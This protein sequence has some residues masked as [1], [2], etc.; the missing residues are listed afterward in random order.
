[1]RFRNNLFY[2]TIYN[3]KFA[4][5]KHKRD[6]HAGCPWALN[7]E[8][9][10]FLT[11]AVTPSVVTGETAL[12][13]KF[14]RIIL[15]VNAPDSP[16]LSREFAFFARLLLQRPS[17]FESGCLLILLFHHFNH[18]RTSTFLVLAKASWE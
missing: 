2:T 12:S 15:R 1:M 8:F 6:V 3:C 13:S 10:S 4:R 18:I 5:E 11:R 9:H 7:E 16:T 14:V 17:E